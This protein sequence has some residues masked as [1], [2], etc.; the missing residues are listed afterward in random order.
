MKT[1]AVG[2]GL[3]GLCASLPTQ[4]ALI[5]L[6]TFDNT[7]SGTSFT[8][9]NSPTTTPARSPFYD[10]AATITTSIAAGNVTPG[11][12]ANDPRTVQNAGSALT[13]GA[14]GIITIQI[15]KGSLTGFGLTYEAGKVGGSPAQGTWQ[16]STTVN[17]TYS[18]VGVAET[19]STGSGFNLNTV[20]FDTTTWGTPANIFLRETLPAGNNNLVQFDN[21]QVTAVPEPIHYALAAFGVIF[22]GVGTGRRFWLARKTV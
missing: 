14:G 10:N 9:D 3:F 18:V 7:V 6:W 13:L 4:A 16:W 15:S 17:G 2:V 19:L 11:T 5:G 8:D 1:L 22:V 20:T 21:F 12:T